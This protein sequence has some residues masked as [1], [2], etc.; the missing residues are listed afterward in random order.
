MR[1]DKAEYEMSFAPQ[2][3]ALIVNDDLTKAQEDIFQAVSNFI[4]A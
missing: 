4:K 3:D 1:L 2:F